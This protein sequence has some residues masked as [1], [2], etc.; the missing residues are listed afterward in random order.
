MKHIFEVMI[1]GLMSGFA[2][3]FLFTQA[4]KPTD[5][6]TTKVATHEMTG[7]MTGNA[8]DEDSGLYSQPTGP[9][10]LPEDFVTA[11]E[12]STQSVIYVRNISQGSYGTFLDYFFGGE[13]GRPAQVST[14]SGVIFT[15]DGYIV[16][17]NHVVEGA[18]KLEV[19][20]N[21][22]SY[23]A[24]IIGTDPSSDLAV[25]KIDARNLPPIPLGNSKNVHVG[26]W[27]LAVGNPFNL[28]STVTAGIV[29]A[30]GRDINILQE[31]FPLES[32]IQ[33]DAAINPGNS[34]GALVNKKG[35]LVGINT[36]I[37]SKTGSYTGYGFAVPVDIVKKVFYDIKTYGEV[38]KAFYGGEVEDFNSEMAKNLDITITDNNFNGVVLVYI[39]K[40]GAA[41]NAGLKEGDIITAIDDQPIN[42]RSLFEEE[43][44]Y[45][46]P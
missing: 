18:D 2:G 29:S 19:Q 28:T 43:L 37:L 22:N 11:S 34:G 16:T 8:F 23:P 31:K 30:K 12:I 20:Y 10:T 46:S 21:K 39:Q 7:V 3:A 6:H 41:K 25:L 27:V 42:T 4:V 26:E 35:E 36:A 24:E 1:I 9:S 17:N 44:S 38:Q 33:T 45:R 14:G 15:T 32:F 40:D 13:Y 5:T